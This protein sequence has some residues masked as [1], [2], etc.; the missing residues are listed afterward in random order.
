VV[1]SHSPS[2]ICHKTGYI[3]ASGQKEPLGYPLPF[4][5]CETCNKL[6]ITTDTGPRVH[7]PIRER[8]TE[9]MSLMF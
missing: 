7:H 8:I 1:R 2:K 3:Q 6:L 4:I 5:A 9:V